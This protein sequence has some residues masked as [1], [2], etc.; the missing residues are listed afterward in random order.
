M[1]LLTSLIICIICYF[2]PAVANN[3][4]ATPEVTPDGQA[5]IVHQLNGSGTTFLNVDSIS[6]SFDLQIAKEDIGIKSA[7]YL[8]A[9]T[10]EASYIRDSKNNWQRWN[11]Q[12]LIPAKE[13]TL[14]A[15]EHLD[16]ISNQNLPVGEYQVYA[17]Y[18]TAKDEIHYNQHPVTLIVFANNSALHLIK[19]SEILHD[20][21]YQG[22][23]NSATNYSY[24]EDLAL[25]IP[26]PIT[27]DA[28]D[29]SF[30]TE[31]S[32][33][34]TNLQE[35]GVDESDRIK[36]D[37]EHLFSLNNCGNDNNQACLNSYLLQASPAQSTLLGS[38]QLSD[39]KT[40]ID[41]SLGELYLTPT[42]DSTPRS[43]I[44]LR[45]LN[46]PQI[47]SV[48]PN[49][50]QT[51][52]TAIQLKF[53]DASDI[54][55]LTITQELTIEGRLMTS[56]LI[57]GILYILSQKSSYYT[58]AYNQESLNTKPSLDFFLPHYQ[59]NNTPAIPL[60]INRCYLFA[61]NSQQY[62]AATLSIITAIPVNN[63]TQYK[64]LC[65]AG[66]LETFYASTTAL[67]FASSRSPYTTQ[68]NQLIYDPAEE[69]VTDIHKFSLLTANM[70]YRGSGQVT[71]HL[72]WEQDK[73][74]FRFGEYAN[75]LRVATSAGSNWGM[76]S[77]TKITV[78]QED[79]TTQSLKEI[80]S[81]DNLGKPGEKLYAARFVGKRGYLV[82][83][84][85]T[86]PLIVIDFSQPQ[87][88]N[89]L[90]ELEIAG[91]S[92]Y[93]QAVGDNYLLG[94]GK[95]AVANA[96]QEGAWY[97]GVKVALFDVS[98]PE[99]LGEIN[100]IVL[101]KRGTEATVLSDHHGLAWLAVDDNHYKLALPVELH[102]TFNKPYAGQNY[103]NPSAFYNW[104]HTGLYVFDIDTKT[105]A[106]KLDG[107]LI[108]ESNT[109]TNTEI[110]YYNFFADR[111]VIQDQSVH[112]IHGNQIISSEI[113][114]LKN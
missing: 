103:D 110:N 95:D 85:V 87:F 46:S 3:F 93:L 92:D 35:S 76:D 99:K 37:K 33:S 69:Q 54:E 109:S 100:S 44:W 2:N 26:A 36:T 24:P 106:L 77:R 98:S 5:A 55:K 70:D 47:Y 71:G 28:A 73:K 19:N 4:I 65:I 41:N 97:Q 6:L 64:S 13:L 31:P 18:K 56:R 61:K 78:L 89:V 82:T 107:K 60:D 58:L 108:T 114:N 50:W 27:T 52:Q 57:D 40:P 74:S 66:E 80:S 22:A 113:R 90:G 101:G 43:L 14:S 67:Y 84:R 10:G 63:P 34:S 48:K 30:S 75:T 45:N 9:K 96:N 29:T 105:P 1:K 51:E 17:A 23:I 25:G 38:L 104:T 42:T 8:V 62:N 32:T 111:A 16:V 94:I 39:E 15:K 12:Q 112:Y 11:N 21:L 86:D 91:Y 88:P 20:Y 49:D 79:S 68:G 59:F 72:G 81:I 7:L 83:F 53:I 102:E